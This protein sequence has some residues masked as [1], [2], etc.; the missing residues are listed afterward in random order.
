M[1]IIAHRGYSGKYPENTM[2]AFEKAIEYGADGI[3]LDIQLTSDGEIVV[4]ND[5]TIDRTSAGSGW[6]KDYTYAQ[7]CEYNFATNFPQYGF[8]K[9]PSLQEVLRLLKPTNLIL[10]IELKTGIVFYDMEERIAAM[11]TEYDMEQRVIFSSF[12][13]SSILKLKNLTDCELAFLYEDGILDIVGYAKKYGISS[14]HPALYNLQY[15][16]VIKDC[17]ENGILLRPWTVNNPT[18]MR[19]CKQAEVEAIITNCVETAV[20]FEETK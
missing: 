8:Q 1:K 11:V 17:H 6:V 9:I 7:L 4:I 5:E 12:N 16:N 3:E 2:L 10:N 15:P 18:H 13:H 14:L 20:G 19:M